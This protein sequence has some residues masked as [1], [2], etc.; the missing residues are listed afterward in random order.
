ME[1]ERT[2]LYPGNVE[3]NERGSRPYR[4][5]KRREDVEETRRRIVDAAVE[6]HGTV[7][8]VNTTFSAVAER[9]GVQRS[10]LYRHFPDEE[11]LFG[12]C[13]SHWLATHPWP[14]VAPWGAIADPRERLR[15]ALRE[16]YAYFETNQQMLANSYRDI[17]VMPP[18]V[19]ELMAAELGAM[20][21]TLLEPW[22]AEARRSTSLA[23]A[24]RHALDFRAWLSLHDAGLPPD[25]AAEL[26]TS[27]VSSVPEPD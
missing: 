8:P 24:L 2:V 7:G 10:T 13:T 26:M 1:I 6:L 27:M 9:A 23:A 22:P 21:S 16:L 14:A 19:R 18:F 17:E 5:R 25:E 4:M 15:R 3:T 12:A 20:H 11:A